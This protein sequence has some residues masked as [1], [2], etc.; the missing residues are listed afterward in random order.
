VHTFKQA[1]DETWRPFAPGKL[2]DRQAVRRVIDS[3]QPLTYDSCA[4]PGYPIEAIW[5]ERLVVAHKLVAIGKQ[6][7]A[8]TLDTLARRAMRIQKLLRRLKRWHKA[9][10]GSSAPKAP[11]G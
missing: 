10:M 5:H 11:A 8:K 9:L 3:P 4:L 1:Y 7:C 2:L 6:P